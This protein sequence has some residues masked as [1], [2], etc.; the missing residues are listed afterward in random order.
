MAGPER[1][2]GE[3]AVLFVPGFALVGSELTGVGCRSDERLVLFADEPLPLGDC[4]FLGGEADGPLAEAG[5][6]GGAI[7]V[8]G[9]C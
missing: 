3:L 7:V 5:A 1:A 8:A 2:L 9:I 4:G 6:G